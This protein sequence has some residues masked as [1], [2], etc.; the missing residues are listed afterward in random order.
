MNFVKRKA[1]TSAKI[2]P[3]HFDELNKQYLFDIYVGCG[4]NEENSH[5]LVFNW[6]HTGINIIPRS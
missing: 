3:S 5:E 2:N 1:S 4:G 6:D